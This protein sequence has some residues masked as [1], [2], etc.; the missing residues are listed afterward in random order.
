MARSLTSPGGPSRNY[1]LWISQPAS[2]EGRRIRL[3]SQMGLNRDLRHRPSHSFS[4]DRLNPIL[5]EWGLNGGLESNGV[6][7]TNAMCMIKN[8]DNGKEFVVKEVKEDGTWK[9]IKELGT[10]RQLTM[11]E[12]SSEMCVGTSPIVQELMRRQNVEDGNKEG[13]DLHSDGSF[14]TASKSKKRASWLKS[15]KS[16]ASSVTGHKERRSSDERDTSSEKGGRRSSSATDDSQ[17]VSFHGPEKVRVRQYG[18]SVKE[19]TAMYKSQEIQAHSGSI[20]AIK[21][22]LDGKYLASAGE[23][24]VIHV[25]QVVETERKGDFFDRSDDGNFNL[26][27]LA[28][29]FQSLHL[30]HRI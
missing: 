24:C 25:W 4:S 29:G 16:V 8:L 6:D 14:G 18:K 2:V 7:E 21:F 13:S 22:S 30:Y 3:L 12:F 1:D 5:P 17:D 28:N 10:G 20:W 9:K 26:L 19:L 23:D 15:I 27:L 11:E